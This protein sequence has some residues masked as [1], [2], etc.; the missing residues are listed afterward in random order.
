MYTHQLIGQHS[1]RRG[2]TLIELLV[3]ISI[4]AI[5]I[6]LLLPALSAARQAAEV[7]LCSS[8][9]RQIAL[10]IQ[11]YANENNGIL[12]FD[13]SLPGVNYLWDAQLG[14]ISAGGAYA[15]LHMESYL[16]RYTVQWETVQPASAVW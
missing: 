9:E 16:P 14:G 11:D 5:L 12:V 6:A 4:I 2:F 1:L 10:A 8:N 13:T 3:V 7:T 15:R